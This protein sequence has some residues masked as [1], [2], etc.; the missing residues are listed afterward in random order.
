MTLEEID[1]NEEPNAGGRQ[2]LML[3]PNDTD[4]QRTRLPKSMNS[5]RNPPCHMRCQGSL[6]PLSS[7]AE[8][9]KVAP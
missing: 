9:V 4:L 2:L 7:R 5:V 8:Q 3:L 1:P 6:T